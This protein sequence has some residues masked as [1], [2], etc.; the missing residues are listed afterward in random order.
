MG[1]TPEELARRFAD[2][3]GYG[4]RRAREA[5]AFVVAGSRSP[6]ETVVVLLFTLPV[7][8]GGC[9]LPAPRLNT[10][11][12]IPASLQLALGKPYLVVDL[13]WEEFGIILEYESY[14]FHRTRQQI[15]SDSARN[16]GLRDLGWMV[17]SV[18][19][20][21][22]ADPQMRRELVEK[23]AARAGVCLP[24]DEGY[25]LRQEALVQELLSL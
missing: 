16:E 9:G 7:E 11:I 8:V 20:G 19:E 18:T 5:V 3:H 10:T 21:M 22:L 25:W 23:V 1:M 17:R 13:C 14:L 2:A 12:E 15:D 6:M 24:E 4:T